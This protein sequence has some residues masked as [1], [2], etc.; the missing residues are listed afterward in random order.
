MTRDPK[1]K[2]SLNQILLAAAIGIFCI[3]LLSLFLRNKSGGGT[4]LRFGGGKKTVV[5]FHFL[6]DKDE[7]LFSVY[8]EFYS[9]EKKAALFFINPL[10]SL[11]DEKTLEDYGKKAPDELESSLEDI[12]DASIPN[13][14]T[15]KASSFR[16]TV[17]LLGGIEF[18]FEPKSNRVTERYE[19]KQKIYRLDGEDAFDVISFL[20]E[21]KLIHYI[22]RLEIQESMFLSFLEAIHHQGESFNKTKVGFLHEQIENNLSLKEWE[23]LFDL[24]KKEKFTFGVSELPAE[25][26]LRTKK[27]D[28]ILKANEET[29]KVAFAKFSSDIRSAYFVDGER[30]RIEVLNGT[31]KSGLARY[32]KSLLNDKGLKVLSVDNAWDSSFTQ[33][34]IL[35]RSG[36]THYT[37]IISETFQGRKVFYALRKDLGLDATVILGEDFQNSKE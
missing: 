11:E 18:F 37:D 8:A 19:R 12:F 29:V 13:Q 21:K 17:D 30:A 34:V 16:K 24:F 25:P 15:F 1:S 28:E 20:K 7:F 3:A 33:S 27:K 2:F 26:I 36:N 31:Q 5:L 22:H 6:S 4:G 14:I 32:G 23:S 10:T 35:N 9:Q